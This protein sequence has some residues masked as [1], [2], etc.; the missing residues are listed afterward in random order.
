[1]SDQTEVVPL[2]EMAGLPEFYHPTVSPDGSKI[3]FYYDET[4][5]NELYVL[6]RASGEYEQITD[7]EVPRSARWWLRWAGRDDEL[8]FHRDE[9]GDEQ[10]DL[11]TV[12]LDGDSEKLVTVDGQG[13]LIDVT[14]D[15]QTVLYASDEGRQLN[16]YSYDRSSEETAQLT[17]YDQPVRGGLFSPAGERLAYVGNETSTLENTDLYLAAADGSDPRRLDVGTEGSETELHDWFPDGERLLVSDNTDD[18]RRVGIYDLGDD[19]VEWLGPHE[20]EESG[21]EVS[22]DGRFVLATRTRRAATV[23]VVYDLDADTSRELD[24]PEGV[25]GFHAAAGRSFLDESTFVYTHSTAADRKRLLEYDLATDD[26]SLLLDADYGSV[27]P[28]TFVDAEFISYEGSGTDEDSDVYEIGALLYDPREGPAV[29]DDATDV[30]AVVFPHGGPPAQSK[31]EFD[32]YSQFL[33]SRGYAVLKPNYRGSTGR[34]RTFKHAIHGDWGGDEQADIADGGRWLQSR[35]WIDED[36]MAIFGGSYGGYSA[37]CQLT[38]YPK[39]WATGIAWIGITDLHKLY[40]DDMPHFQHMLRMQMGDPEQNYDRW[41]DRSPIEHVDAM[42]RPIFIIHGV[43]DPRCPIEQA[44][45]FRDALEDRGWAVGE[46]FEYEELGD[47]GHG[48]TDIQQKIRA[49]ELVGDYLER[50]L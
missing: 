22:P 47:E 28:D 16:L 36:R 29:A 5:R 48:S 4:G 15:G 27:D 1:M 18:L 3:A 6:D 40:E 11:H 41:R 30:P 23:P 37:Y 9:D 19:T 12:S 25:V 45:I 49:F 32:L 8:L 26:S 43:N 38:Q 14:D 34:G 17:D 13:I 31:R 2:E 35:A 21:V 39:L 33:V 42:E 10:N 24:V 44:R 20:A 46:D 7:G 50:R